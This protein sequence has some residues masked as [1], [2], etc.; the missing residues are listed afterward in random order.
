MQQEIDERLTKS[1]G[2]LPVRVPHRREARSPK[3]WP[4]YDDTPFEDAVDRETGDVIVPGVK[5]MQAMTG[6]NP[7]TIRL[8]EHENAARPEVIEWA[9]GLEADLASVASE[10]AI[11]VAL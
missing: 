6:I 11:R 8:Y 1:A 7:E 4:T 10:E 5:T 2:D 3:P 9:E